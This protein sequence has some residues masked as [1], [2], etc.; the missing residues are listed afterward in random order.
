MALF[1][2]PAITF[3]GRQV[4]GDI[5]KIMKDFLNS[6]SALRGAK[7]LDLGP[8]ARARGVVSSGVV[9]LDVLVELLLKQKLSKNASVRLSKW[10]D[11]VLTVLQKQVRL[12]VYS[13]LLVLFTTY[14]FHLLLTLYYSN[15]TRRGTRPSFNSNST[16]RGTRP[17]FNSNSTR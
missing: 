10:S 3:V 11:K 12:S 17:S 1:A 9:R 8:M 16:R 14:S 7:S 2:N 4:G 5:K 6:A 13:L 15:S